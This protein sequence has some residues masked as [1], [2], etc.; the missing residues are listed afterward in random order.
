MWVWSLVTKPTFQNFTEFKSIV[1]SC[2]V[3][4]HA[5]HRCRIT[6]GGGIAD[7]AVTVVSKDVCA[8]SAGVGGV[9]CV[10]PVTDRVAA[11]CDTMPWTIGL[12]T[13]G[14]FVAAAAGVRAGTMAG[15]EVES[16]VAALTAGPLDF[17]GYTC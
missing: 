11:I 12:A 6:N 10:E 1:S 16:G 13:D 14:L 5:F 2:L 15:A 4:A 7:L 3:F 9:F 17:P 8:A